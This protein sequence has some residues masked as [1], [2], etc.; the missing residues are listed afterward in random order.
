[1]SLLHARC[2]RRE[3]LHNS[4]RLRY[5]WQ[6]ARGINPLLR[7]RTFSHTAQGCQ[8]RSVIS[9]LSWRMPTSARRRIDLVWDLVVRGLSLHPWQ[10]PGDAHVDEPSDRLSSAFSSVWRVPWRNRSAFEPFGGFSA[11]ITRIGRRQHVTELTV[12]DRTREYLTRLKQ[13]SSDWCIWETH[14][15]YSF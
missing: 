13:I 9:S 7:R 8:E 1:M 5:D 3:L 12:C 15:V 6:I 10:W 2:A 4:R 11:A 14:E